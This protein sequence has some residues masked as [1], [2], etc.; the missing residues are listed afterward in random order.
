MS[1]PS[2]KHS[3]ASWTGFPTIE[4]TF[5]P[6]MIRRAAAKVEQLFGDVQPRAPETYDLQDLHRRVM[7]SWN[8]DRALAGLAPRDLRRLPWILFYPV[9]EGN[10]SRDAGGAKWLGAETAVLR[11]YGRW[12]STG[13]R[14]RSVLALVYEFLRV[15]PVTLPTFNELRRLLHDTVESCSAPPTASLRRWRRRCQDFGLLEKDGAEAFVQKLMSA[16]ESMEDILRKAGLDAGLAR[17]GFLE[18]GIRAY[19]TQVESLLR[20]DRLGTAQL[21]RL[22]HI[23]AVDSRLRFDDR[24][25]RLEV[26]TTLLRPFAEGR[27][28]PAVRERLQPFFLRHFG[29]P[30]LRKHRWSGVPPQMQRVVIR[31]LNERALEQFLLLIRE[32]AF[33]S[34]WRYREAFWRKFLRLDPDIWCVLGRDA[35]YRLRKM[36]AE[37]DEPETTVML[38]GAGRDQSV[39]LLRL[40]GVTIAEWSHNGACRIWLDGTPG[41]P[42]LYKNEYSRF[43]LTTDADFRLTHLGQWQDRIIDWLRFNTDVEIDHDDY[44]FAIAPM[45]SKIER[46]S[47]SLSQAF[48]RVMDG[49]PSTTG[50][51]VQ[52]RGMQ[53]KGRALHALAYSELVAG[54]SDDAILTALAARRGRPVA[55]STVKSWFKIFVDCG[56]IAYQN[57]KRSFSNRS[58]KW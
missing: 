43:E 21:D 50:E 41:A 20:D 33:D 18:S 49:S 44:K 6:R 30:R 32:T 48:S 9:R 12:L 28:E 37:S 46:T 58:R 3:L 56:R 5:E 39:L 17:C 24:A 57:E 55:Y 42:E 15:Y 11:E 1:E 52:E 36:N 8:R 47:N 40:P 10:R 7:E 19:L 51:V 53:S 4:R 22:L 35:R 25:M 13:R 34:Q 16:T 31:W 2:L 38:R 29:D 14:V 27:A 54:S 45:A 26:A 23:L